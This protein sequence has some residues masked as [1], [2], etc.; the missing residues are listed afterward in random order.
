MVKWMMTTLKTRKAWFENNEENIPDK[1]KKI[2]IA[3]SYDLGWQKRSTGRVYDSISGHGYLIGCR[4]GKIIGM[5]VRQIKCKNSK[6]KIAMGHLQLLMSV[7]SIGM[8][9]AAQWRQLSQWI[10]LYQYMRKWRNAFI[11]KY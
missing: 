4:T 6:Q 2:G 3:I 9:A 7:W 5:Q 8:V 10:L 11:A 1:I